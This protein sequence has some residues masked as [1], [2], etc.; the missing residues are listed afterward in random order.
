MNLGKKATVKKFFIMCQFV[1][2]S[3]EYFLTCH[4]ITEQEN[5]YMTA[6]IK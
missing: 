3:S 6:G 2:E 5:K 1:A 4:M